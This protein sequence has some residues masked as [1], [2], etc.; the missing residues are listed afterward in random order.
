[1]PHTVE[2]NAIWGPENVNGGAPKS[3]YPNKT[4][5]GIVPV[6]QGYW[7]SF[8]KSYNPNT[9]SLPGTPTWEEWTANGQNW[10]VFQTNNTKM[11][12]VDAGL[13]Q[14]HA[15]MESIGLSIRQ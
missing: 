7:T 13:Q 11:E 8:I 2:V 10:L 6:V 9:Y 3:Y 5:A 14:R 1:M 15:F 12:T 4:N